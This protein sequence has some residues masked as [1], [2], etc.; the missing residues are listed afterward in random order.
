MIKERGEGARRTSVAMDA[1]V[2]RAEGGGA[3]VVLISG[4]QE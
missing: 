3:A 1:A 4:R 2:K